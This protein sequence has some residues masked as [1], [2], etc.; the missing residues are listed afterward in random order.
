MRWNLT[1]LAALLVAAC[2]TPG[3]PAQSAPE[4]VP[5]FKG[6]GA[7][8][9]TVSTTSAKAQE[10]FDQGLALNYGFN[11][12]EAVRSYAEAARID[13]DCAMAWWGQAYALGP[14]YNLPFHEENF[15][16]AYAAIREAVARKGKATPAERD[17]IDALALRFEKEPHPDRLPLD[18]A[19]S[20]AMAKLW[21]KYPRDD[22]IG[23]LY[24]DS[25]MVLNP[26]NLWNKD[27]SP[28]KNTPEIVATL[29]RVM[30]I[31]PNHPGA[32]H[33]YIHAVEAS[34]NPGRAEAAADRLR[35]L[36]PG[37]GHLVHMPAHIYVQI[38]R[39]MDAIECNEEASKRDS[40]YFARRGTQGIYHFYHVHN[41][42]FLVWSAMFS[43][44]D[45]D[46]LSRC[47]IMVRNLPEAFHSEPAAAEFLS[48]KLHV[49]IRFGRWEEVLKSPAQ[50][51]DQPYAV[52]MW[53][54]ARG[55]AFANTKRFKEAEQELAK[56]DVA[57][58]SV[59]ADMSVFLTPGHDV[60]KV[61]REMLLGETAFKSGKPELAFT[62]LRAAVT[63]ED[64]LR[65]Q[66]P[67]PW[68]MPTRHALGALLMQQDKVSEAEQVYR[69][70]LKRFP[71]NVWSLQ[72]L[73]ECL[74][75]R[76]AAEAKDVRRSFERARA[77]ATVMIGA[78]C[79]CRT[80]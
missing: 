29:E 80:K 42:H 14:N 50:R 20:E 30:E 6:M 17:L 25:L 43:G 22:D 19:Y 75:R 55:V 66:E 4:P 21:K 56:F 53:H 35:G 15:R 31:N 26:W 70:D 62:H 13:P 24:A 12:D 49:L 78:S 51:K 41:D 9:R 5:L 33:L 18:H 64:A 73:T 61:A 48:T 72:G 79:Y 34:R 36:V 2:E 71:K 74:E 59:P 16:K 8:K 54:Y 28:D 47:D 65:Y 52:A 3:K 76:K 40:E 32:N 7:H 63:A 77:N 44:R 60:L 67:S 69:T 58:K 38:G 39:Y 46:A 68:M 10:Y 1:I 23:V 37:S 57:V 11:H 27:G 45:K